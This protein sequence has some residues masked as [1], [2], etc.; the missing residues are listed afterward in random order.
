MFPHV[1]EFFFSLPHVSVSREMCKLTFNGN[2]FRTFSAQSSAQ[3]HRRES[4]NALESPGTLDEKFDT[5]LFSDFSAKTLE[6]SF[7]AVSTP[8]F[9]SKYSFCSAFRDL[10]DCH[11]FAPL[12]TQNL[13]KFL[14]NVFICLL[15]F[16]QKSRFFNIFHRILH[17]CQ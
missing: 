11:T 5:E 9:A 12:E 2:Q 15:K 17:Q 16:L 13:R 14:P 8:I 1:S 10:Q 4:R 3:P 6:G 7:S